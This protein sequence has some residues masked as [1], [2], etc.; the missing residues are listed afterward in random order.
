MNKI[1]KVFASSRSQIVLIIL[2][3]TI[4]L[5]SGFQTTTAVLTYFSDTYVTQAQ[6]QQIGVS[7]IENGKEVSRFDD[8]EDE[9]YIPEIPQEG[10]QPG[11]SYKEELRVKNCGGNLSDENESI[12]EYVRVIVRKRWLNNDSKADTSLDPQHI[13]LHYVT[14]DWI[15]DESQSTLEQTVLYYKNILKVNEESSLF[16]DC[17]SIDANILKEAKVEKVQDG[18]KVITHYTYDDVQFELSVQVDAVQT[19]NAKDAILSAWGV[20]VN[21]SEDGTLS[22]GGEANE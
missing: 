11:K 4:L 2:V 10:L 5:A 14:D 22:L 16:M 20:Q 18:N 9:L 8:T 12:D 6:M 19:H 15:I 1:K 21:I 17:L 7:L 13:Q 3:A